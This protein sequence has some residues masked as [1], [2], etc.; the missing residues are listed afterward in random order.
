MSVQVLEQLGSRDVSKTGGKLSA[1][2]SF[3]VWDD[4]DAL[5][6]PGS[7][8]VLFGTG[9]L[10]IYGE[11][12]PESPNLQARDYRLSRVDGHRDLWLVEWEYA[13]ASLISAS[14]PDLQPG[15]TGYVE[16]TARIT[17]NFVDAWRSLTTTELA[18]LTKSGGKYA[19]GG[20]NA[21]RLDIGGAPI[22]VAGEPTQQ[23]VRQI[24]VQ[25][26]EVQSGIPNLT[27]YLPFI[28]SRNNVAFMGAPVG[29]L[30]Y[31]GANVTRIDVAKF[32]WQHTFVLD[33]WWHMRQQPAKW[34][35]GKVPTMGPI[36]AKVAE[37]VFF[38]Q[39]FP[40]YANFFAMSPN[41]TQVQSSQV[42]NVPIIG[43][44]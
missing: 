3:H 20:N 11:T 18:D 10:P 5:A 25:V 42:I 26:T 27:S 29:Q 13:E 2:R 15:E 24:E 44:P 35:D 41:F 32:Q 6:T 17:A 12:F 4:A 22:D 23:V 31:V 16:V 39:P 21:L 28:W 40:S 37:Q 7:V 19:F 43:F 38:V 14:I 36:G 1:R 8:V 34:P 9:G 33:R 30:L